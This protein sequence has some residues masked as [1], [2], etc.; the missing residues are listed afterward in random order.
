MGSLTDCV[1][2]A[3]AGGAL[4]QRAGVR[5]G[6]AGAGGGGGRGSAGGAAPG[7]AHLP[8]SRRERTDPGRGA[9]R[10]QVSR[11]ASRFFH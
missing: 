2:F 6:C 5:G 3:G 10:T 4:Q 1:H 7:A 8:V 11:F 9:Q